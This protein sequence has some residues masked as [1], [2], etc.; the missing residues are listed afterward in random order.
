MIATECAPPVA[1]ASEHQSFVVE[2]HPVHRSTALPE[3]DVSLR[4]MAGIATMDAE[5]NDR[6]IREAHDRQLNAARAVVDDFKE[7][8]A[9]T[10]QDVPT[11]IPTSTTV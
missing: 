11:T 3:D 5:P 8:R 10:R 9:A 2:P 4:N 6:A 1:V 7:C